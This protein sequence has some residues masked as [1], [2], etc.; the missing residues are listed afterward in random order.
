MIFHFPE[1]VKQYER[2]SLFVKEE[3]WIRCLQIAKERMVDVENAINILLKGAIEEYEKV[4][5][6]PKQQAKEVIESHHGDEP[7]MPSPVSIKNPCQ[8]A[9]ILPDPSKATDPPEVD[10]SNKIRKGGEVPE[11]M[12]HCDNP[13]CSSRDELI[14]ASRMCDYKKY[15]MCSLVCVEDFRRSEERITETTETEKEPEEEDVT[16]VSIWHKDYPN[17]CVDCKSKKQKHASKGLCKK[18]YARHY[19]NSKKK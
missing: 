13:K 6:Q 5:E 11:K 8:I 3:I 19:Y 12:Y 9:L 2:H 15:H 14:P 10:L 1:P 7:E 17:G 18:C 4:Y 16:D